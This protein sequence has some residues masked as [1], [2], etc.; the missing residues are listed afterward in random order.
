MRG[1]AAVSIIAWHELSAANRAPPS[2]AG[3]TTATGNHGRHNHRTTLP[4]RGC[5]ASGYDPPGDFV[6]QHQRKRMTRR[7]S[8]ESKADVRMADS[9]ACDLNDDLPGTRLKRGE[10]L[11]LQWPGLRGQTVAISA[12][13]NS[14]VRPSLAPS[15]LKLCLGGLR[16]RRLAAPPVITTLS[17][18]C[19]RRSGPGCPAPPPGRGL[20][21]PAP[22]A[23]E[24]CARGWRAW[25]QT[26]GFE[27][28]PA[29]ES[30]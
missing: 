27:P 2:R 18:H 4:V 19:P 22:P 11:K 25:F 12:A 24:Q 14:Q 8:V 30:T 21:S 17:G 5:R 23:P 26:T 28:R 13:D 3:G 9:A 6:A 10:C 16:G 29:R 20:V 7:D 15:N 1:E